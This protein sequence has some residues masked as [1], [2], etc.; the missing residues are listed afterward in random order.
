MA[1]QKNKNNKNNNSHKRVYRR[2]KNP[3]KRVQN[4]EKE[5]TTQG[6][7]QQ[8]QQQHTANKQQ[9][10][11][12]TDQHNLEVSRVI[13]LERLQ[14]FADDLTEHS[15]SCDG[16]IEKLGQVWHPSSKVTAQT[17]STLLV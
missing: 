13:N 5:N 11:G 15:T 6:T 16:S 14:Q 4:K 3:M 17:V 8:Q 10:L 7:I 9:D 12:T 1:N 2:K